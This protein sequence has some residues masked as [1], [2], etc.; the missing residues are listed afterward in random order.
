MGTICEN[1]LDNSIEEQKW[2]IKLLH[3]KSKNILVGVAP[4]DFDINS[5]NEKCGWYYYCNDS[6]LYP[7]SPHNYSK[8]DQV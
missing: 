1:K 7:G 8:K 6:T 4:I 5:S 3:S 2:K